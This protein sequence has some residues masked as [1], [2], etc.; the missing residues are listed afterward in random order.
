MKVNLGH[1]LDELQRQTDA[2]T[3]KSC[4][5]I[6]L[7]GL[8]VNLD[9]NGTQQG[10]ETT[11]VGRVIENA[12]KAILI[13]AHSRSSEKYT[14]FLA[15]VASAMVDGWDEIL[16]GVKFSELNEAE[17]ERFVARQVQWLMQYEIPHKVLMDYLGDV[18]ECKGEWLQS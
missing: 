1:V 13:N 5:A 11:L 16:A 12:D 10:M 2:V 8:S 15:N 4:V 6:R 3:R 17:Q 9:A 7:S 14:L 18:L